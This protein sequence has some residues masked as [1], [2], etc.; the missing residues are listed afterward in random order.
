MKR[1]A[2]IG[3]G[4]AGLSLAHRLQQ[5]KVSNVDISLFEKSRGVGGRLAT[6][7]AEPYAFD[8]GAQYFTARQPSFCEFLQPLI[9][10]GM[11]ARWSTRCIKFDYNR[12]LGYQDWSQ[13]EPRYVATPT[14]SA[15]CKHLA[16]GFDVRLNTRITAIARP[17]DWQLLDQN[18]HTHEGFDWVI[19][20]IPSPQA[21]NLLPPHFQHYRCVAR[22]TMFACFSLMLGFDQPLVLDFDAARVV[23]ADLSWIAVNN[24]KPSRAGAFSLIA[25]SSHHFASQHLDDDKEQLIETLC[26]TTTSILGYDVRRA[27]HQSIHRWLY[28]NTEARDPLPILLDTA[29]NL[30]V[31]GDW[32]HGGR[33]EGAF[34][35]ARQLADALIDSGL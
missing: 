23:N 9:D 2:I 7:R 15:L 11:V 27:E 3:T 6:R 24:H 31:C 18:G 17:G 35:S 26:E 5:R 32:C 28:A 14:M 8:H 22:V 13:D 4:L 12:R 30:A 20:A 34:L 29:K 19:L 10:V 1:V 21:V 16:V 33:V 25:H